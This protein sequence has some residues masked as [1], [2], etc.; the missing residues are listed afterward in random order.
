MRGRRLLPATA[1]RVMGGISMAMCVLALVLHTPGHISFDSSM[2]LH[3]AAT[4]IAVSWNPP[5]MSA[6]LR[7]LGG[8]ALAAVALMLINVLG[9]YACLWTIARSGIRAGSDA[10]IATWRVLWCALLIAN[11]VIFLYIGILW[12]DVLMATLMLLALTLALLAARAH[13]IRR[14]L[15]SVLA[16]VVLLPMPLTRQQGWFLLPI[17]LAA[18]VWLL[19]PRAGRRPDQLLRATT[20]VLSTV[21]AMVLLS[22]AVARTIR[23]DGRDVFNGS[24]A[25]MA[26][27]VAGA[28][29]R[30]RSAGQDMMNLLQPPAPA[31]ERITVL[32]SPARSDPLVDDPVA[33]RYLGRIKPAQLSAAWWILLRQ[34]PRV[35]LRQRWDAF[36]WLLDMHDLQRCLPIHVGVAGMP[37]YLDELRIRQGSDARDDLLFALS[38]KAQSTILYRHWFY[39]L[40]LPLALALTWFAR[41]LGAARGVLVVHLL[42]LGAYLLSFLPTSLACDF[43]YLYPLIPSL[44]GT[45]IFLL[46]AERANGLDCDDQ[47]K[48]NTGP[49]PQTASEPLSRITR[50]TV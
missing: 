16:I 3:E 9:T 26:Y 41:A 45:L 5:F 46:L 25:V 1:L 31:W 38:R 27:D 39:A 22:F 14:F 7:W 35:W 19:A 37:D 12:K 13:G 40:L 15:L 10:A 47:R 29:A 50:E 34:H 32:Y 20:V 23:G 2:Q 42:G 8:N 36:A 48:P 44:S 49:S 4:G 18:P 6:L 24:R 43:R 11:P 33:G 30:S 17:L 21:L 28:I